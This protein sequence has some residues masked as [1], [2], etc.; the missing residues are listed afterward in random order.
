MI[1]VLKSFVRSIPTL[2]LSLA[3]S[4]AVWISAVNAADPVKQ[5][6]YPRPVTI[7]RKG[8]DP[9]LVISSDVPTQVS[10]TFSAPTSIWERMINDRAPVHAWIDLSG[11]GPGTHTIPVK[12]EVLPQFRPSRLVAQS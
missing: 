3:L 9:A 10:A 8:L 4:V 11:L 2:I 6:L 7:E 12:V 5:Q 1:S